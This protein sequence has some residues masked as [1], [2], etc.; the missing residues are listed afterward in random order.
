LAKAFIFMFI[1]LGVILACFGID[2]LS[3]LFTSLS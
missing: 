1:F 3:R 2:V